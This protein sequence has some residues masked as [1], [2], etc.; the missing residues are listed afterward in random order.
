MSLATLRDDLAGASFQKGICI[1]QQ[2][3]HTVARFSS[4]AGYEK[5]L[6]AYASGNGAEPWYIDNYPEAEWG[7]DD[8]HA[9]DPLL[10]RIRAVAEPVIWG[11]DFYAAAGAR[12]L[13]QAALPFGFHSGITAPIR[14][15]RGNRM[16][17]SLSRDQALDAATS[18]MQAHEI[19]IVAL[20]LA[21]TVA[22]FDS[23][24]RL[25]GSSLHPLALEALR[26]TFDGLPLYAVSERLR[27]APSQVRFL[28][29]QAKQQLEAGSDIEAT[30]IA[31]RY[32][33]LGAV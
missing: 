23:A 33:L 14:P 9:R 5:Y 17:L 29:S 26:W 25:F 3:T 7:P 12:D 16:V 20:M 8:A 11:P 21:G 4:S 19:N 2:L 15:G 18:A 28:L 30:M 13:W 6:L 22:S 24:R 10:A 31:A 32:G 1:G 27:Q